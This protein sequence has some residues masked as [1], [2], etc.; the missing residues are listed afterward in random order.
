MRT[1]VRLICR[2]GIVSV[3]FIFFLVSLPFLLGRSVPLPRY[4]VSKPHFPF[5]VVVVAAVVF[6]STRQSRA[7][8]DPRRL[9][10]EKNRPRFFGQWR[11]RHV[12]CRV[13]YL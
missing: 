12:R 3:S 11:C 9:E 6:G 5:F 13:A 7:A 2:R 4:P 10:A 8:V 1:E